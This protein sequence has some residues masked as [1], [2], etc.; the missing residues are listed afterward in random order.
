MLVLHV[1]NGRLDDPVNQAAV[2]RAAE[3]IRAVPHVTSVAPC[4]REQASLSDDRRTGYLA[5]VTDVRLREVDRTLA[6]AIDDAAAPA[7]DA[8][9]QAVAGVV[10]T[11][12]LDDAD[13]RTS[14]VLGLAMAAL[15]LVLAFRGV[16]AATLPLATALLTLLCLWVERHR[17]GRPSRE[18]TECCG[19]PGRDDRHRRR[20]RAVPRHPAS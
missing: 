19:Q 20:L 14:E 17:S 8:G 5:M 16:V 12:A 9:I 13:T 15:V 18:R 3:Q 2:N 10:F 6:Q 1:N 7:R 4:S 11:T